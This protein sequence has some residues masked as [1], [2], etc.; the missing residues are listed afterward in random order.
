MESIFFTIPSL[1]MAT[2]AP[3]YDTWEVEYNGI[4]SISIPRIDASK[5][6]GEGKVQGVFWEFKYW[7]VSCIN[8][9]SAVS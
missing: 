6:A 3:N 5:L 8:H 2:Q 7:Y 9:S 1:W 4:Y